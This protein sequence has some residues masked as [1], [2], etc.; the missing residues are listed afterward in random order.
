MDISM[1]TSTSWLSFPHLTAMR[2]QSWKAL[3]STA[4]QPLSDPTHRGTQGWQLLP[5]PVYHNYPHTCAA[6]ACQASAWFPVLNH[7]RNALISYLQDLDR[8]QGRAFNLPHQLVGS[9]GWALMPISPKL[10]WTAP[11]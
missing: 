6:G 5:H 10:D 1:E 9:P 4:A 3:L 8:V 11:A 2:I 7:P